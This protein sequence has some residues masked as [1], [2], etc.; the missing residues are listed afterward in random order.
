MIRNFARMNS[1][2]HYRVEVAE[3]TIDP[4][5]TATATESVSMSPPTPPHRSFLTVIPVPSPTVYT[6]PHE[7]YQYLNLIHDIMQQ[8]EEYISRNGST[9]SV[10]GAG[11]VFSLEQGRIPILTTKK[12]AWKTCQKNY[13]GL[14]KGKQIIDYCNKLASISGTIMH[15]P[16]SLLPADYRTVQRATLARYMVIN[17]AILMRNMK[18][19]RQ[20]IRDKV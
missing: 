4:K 2:P 15:H 5:N 10:F 6:H 1:I 20:I 14:F 18:P 11:M 8:N 9:I 7:E 19:T 17:G 13:C 12:M 16:I 3:P